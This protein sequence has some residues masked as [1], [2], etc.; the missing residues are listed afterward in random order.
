MVLGALFVVSLLL[1]AVFLYKNRNLKQEL[2]RQNGWI[3]GVNADL[4]EAY[5]ALHEKARR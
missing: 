2:I 5:A 1:N 4:N 3:K